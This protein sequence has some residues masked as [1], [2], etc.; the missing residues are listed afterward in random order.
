MTWNKNTLTLALL[1]T[2]SASALAIINGESVD[3]ADYPEIARTNFDGS[4]CTAT[5]L[6][7]KWV[8]TADHC[9]DG[10][11]AGGDLSYEIGA[12]IDV[13]YEETLTDKD[14][15]FD[16]LTVYIREDD[17]WTVYEEVRAS[18]FRWRNQDDAEEAGIEATDQ[19]MDD[20]RSYENDELGKRSD[21]G[22]VELDESPSLEGTVYIADLD[23]IN[24]PTERA[25]FE[26]N[27]DGTAQEIMMLAIGPEDE[28]TSFS[29]SGLEV[30]F[31][32]VHL[33]IDS[34]NSEVGNSNC[35]KNNG[36][37][38]VTSS[39]GSNSDEI[40]AGSAS[41]IALRDNT[42]GDYVFIQGGNSGAGIRWYNSVTD[43]FELYAV[44]SGN[45]NYYY[46]PDD[47]VL[48]DTA[49]N[50]DT[51]YSLDMSD[52]ANY[53]RSYLSSDEDY[54]DYI[55][56]RKEEIESHDL[57]PDVHGVNPFT[58]GALMYEPFQ[59]HLLYE[60]NALNAPKVTT[61]ESGESVE[62]RFQNLTL[63]S[64]DMA[65][66]LTVDGD[67]EIESYSYTS[68]DTDTETTTTSTDCSSIEPLESCVLTLTSTG[69]EGTVNMGFDSSNQP[70]QFMYV[71][72]VADTDDD[73]DSSTTT[74]S[75]SDDDNSIGGSFGW[76]G[77]LGLCFAVVRRKMA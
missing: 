30:A 24:L 7:H 71:N 37:Y 9:I 34:V 65:E 42:D 49:L 14:D 64:V 11:Y 67:V 74:T 5:V 16:D 55:E 43:D 23:A 6:A 72:Y 59:N 2:L 19:N 31:G 56:L 57:Y 70:D 45:S 50:D 40:K 51:D 17:A 21:I 62:V 20:G 33:F 12:T 61:I 41:T 46:F 75:S 25:A 36:N 18:S 38:C 47:N 73:D 77:L 26:E 4:N 27:D 48:H 69:G 3:Y 53:G 15:W 68:Y 63:D 22:L 76:L 44:V 66:I 8:I 39:I 32:G 28:S 35:T 52:I 29:N 60:I 10:S 13:D 1:S 58:A 54:W